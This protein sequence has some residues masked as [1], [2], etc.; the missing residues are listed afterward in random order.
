MFAPSVVA[1][2][3]L[4][5]QSDMRQRARDAERARVASQADLLQRQAAAKAPKSRVRLRRLRW[6][7]P[8]AVQ[9]R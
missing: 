3:H 9:P 6:R 5:H 2:I 4:A 7:S 8:S 1:A